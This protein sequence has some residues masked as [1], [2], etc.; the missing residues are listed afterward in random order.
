MPMLTIQGKEF[1]IS[2]DGVILDTNVLVH[3]YIDQELNKHNDVNL[4]FNEST[5][6]W[7]ISYAVVQEVWGMINSR[8]VKAQAHIIAMDFLAWLKQPGENIIVIPLDDDMI[9]ETKFY[10]KME[11]D[12]VDGIIYQLALKI[13][14]QCGVIPTIATYDTKDFNKILALGPMFDL[15][16]MH[17]SAEDLL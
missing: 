11:V 10:K 17:S 5:R 8:V 4:I 6:Q 13:S 15:C 14:Q 3:K 16:D 12:C 1:D 9:A 2:R 7:I